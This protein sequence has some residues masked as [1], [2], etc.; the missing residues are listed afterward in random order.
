[1]KKSYTL[2]I[3]EDNDSKSL[4][5]MVLEEYFS[6]VVYIKNES[7]IISMYNHYSPDVLMVDDNFIKKNNFFISKI[8]SNFNTCLICLS[9]S[10]KLHTLEDI[11]TQKN[12][13][14]FYAEEDNKDELRNIIE[15]SF[16]ILHACD[17]TYYENEF[18]DMNT[19]LQNI[20]LPACVC[21]YDLNIVG[22]NSLFN[23]VFDEDDMPFIDINTIKKH[24]KNRNLHGQK[25]ILINNEKFIV[26]IYILKQ[27]EVYLIILQ[28]S[29]NSH[30]TLSTSFSLEMKSLLDRIEQNFEDFE[31]IQVQMLE[32][33]SYLKN[34]LAGNISEEEAKIWIGENQELILNIE[35]QFDYKMLEELK[36]QSYLI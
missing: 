20:S 7:E 17:T 19:L 18:L 25:S 11:L 32:L 31:N 10:E 27:Y 16:D 8:H 6:T 28:N 24:I 33:S 26:K 34:F 13:L 12:I 21:K 30:E 3:Y 2:L 15:K 23:G 36:N 4:D 22:A 35:N 5:K 14:T 9:S 29:N 1:M